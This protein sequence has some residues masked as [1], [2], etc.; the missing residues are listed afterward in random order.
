MLQKTPDAVLQRTPEQAHNQDVRP[1]SPR[2]C[3]LAD[4]FRCRSCRRAVPFCQFPVTFA[5]LS[6]SGS[7]C[8]RCN[9]RHPF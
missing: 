1:R 6:P 8:T 4:H 9:S 5:R 2:L 7:C 3:F